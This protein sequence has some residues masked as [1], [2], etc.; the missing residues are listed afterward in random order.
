MT[1]HKELMQRNPP[2]ENRSAE[3]KY[4]RTVLRWIRD[5]SND[6]DVVREAEA[7]LQTYPYLRSKP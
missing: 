1:A 5:H 2:R 3:A 4:Y 7:A 6:P